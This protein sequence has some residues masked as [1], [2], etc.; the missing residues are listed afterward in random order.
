MKPGTDPA[1]LEPDYST[2]VAG[3]YPL[4]MLTYAAV[5]PLALDGEARSHYAAFLDYVTDEGQV[6]GLEPGELPNG[7]TPLPAA[8]KA[9]AA[10]AATLIRTMEAPPAAPAEP[11]PTDPSSSSAFP[12]SSGP[13]GSSSARATTTT[14]PAAIQTEL[15]AAPSEVASTPEAGPLTPILAL[16][17]SRYFLLVLAVLALGSTVI[18]LEITKRPRRRTT[19]VPEG[20]S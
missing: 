12:T 5:K 9:Q 13:S 7:Y 18:A 6:A 2:Q 15:A 14:A 3:A 10:E 20:P 8:L 17:R 4:A 11:G 1:V 19:P 16:A